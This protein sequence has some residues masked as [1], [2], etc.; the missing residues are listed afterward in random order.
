M[1]SSKLPPFEL[2]EEPLLAFSPSD[3]EQ[4]SM[5]PLRGLLAHGPF[6]KGSFGGYTSCIRIATVGPVSAFKRRG[7]LM[8]S[9][10]D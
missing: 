1:A 4:M 9:L 7:V 8:A 5:H 3:P 10:R 6:S 2:L